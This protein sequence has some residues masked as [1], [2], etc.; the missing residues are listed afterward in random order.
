MNFGQWLIYCIF[1]ILHDALGSFHVGTVITAIF[2]ADGNGIFSDW[3]QKHVFVGKTSAHHTGI[4]CNGNYFRNT[5]SG[6]DAVV[7]FVA[8][9]IVTLQIFLGS[10]ER[11]SI[12]HSKFTDTDQS[13]ARSC[14][15]TELC[16]DLVDHKWI[17]IITFGI[18]TNKLN[19]G[20]LVCHS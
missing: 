14:L 4:G 16:L 9:L 2:L 15:I 1:C 20:F 11:I 13:G 8:D 3:C 19:S 6:K 12:F 10:V 18:I 5:G 7:C 17:I